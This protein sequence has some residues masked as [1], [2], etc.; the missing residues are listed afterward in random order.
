[1]MSPKY[2]AQRMQIRY[3]LGLMLYQMKLYQLSTFQFISVIR[4]GNSRFVAKSLEKLSLAANE[5]GDDTLLNYAISRVKVESFPAVHRDML[6]YRIAEFQLRN[7]QMQE[8]IE[9]FNHIQ[10]TSPLFD[11][12]LYMKG[13]AYAQ[14][15]DAKKSI[16]NYDQLLSRN[17]SAAVTDTTRVAAL[18][19]KARA[20]YQNKEWSESIQAY[21]DVP[22]DTP[23]WHDTIFESSW[24]MLRSGKFRSVISNFQSLH[25]PYYEENYLPESLLL[26]SIVYLYICQYD[27]MDKVLLLFN[28]IYRAVFKDISSYLNSS[29]S[30]NQYFTDAIV[31]IKAAEK[32]NFDPAKTRF[33]APYMVTHK[34]SKEGD[35]QRSLQYVMKLLSERKKVLALPVAWRSTGM[36]K[37]SLQTLDRRIDKARNK[38]G[39]QIRTHM[40]EI[41]SELVDLFEQEGLIRYEML[42]GRKEILKKKVAG[43]EVKKTRIGE[44]RS[45]DYYIQNGYEYWPFRG[46]YW[47]DEIGNYHYLGT[48]SCER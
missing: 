48:S 2:E 37:Y 24:A 25:S 5:L 29:K 21:R 13:L 15:G 31:A 33:A 45:Q 39:R 8:S 32:E 4:D 9:S 10:E 22:R 41:R 27:E 34:I 16:E 7:S 44:E 43:K 35:F 6:Y 11:K 12:A 26:R 30:P 19:G 14:L 38:A 23:Y 36:G 28:R 17:Q 1:S 47:L 46:E 20:L 3:L 40:I 42:N 18:M